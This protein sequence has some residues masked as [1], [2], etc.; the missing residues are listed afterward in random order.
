MDDARLVAVDQS[1]FLIGIAPPQKINDR[2][3]LG[4]EIGNGHVGDL[5][6]AIFGMTV[7][8]SLPNGE[9]GVEKQYPLLRPRRQIA[10]SL[11]YRVSILVRKLLV[12]VHKRRREHDAFPDRKSQ[13]V[14]LI[15]VEIG[16]LADDDDFHFLFR[17]QPKGA[18]DIL[19]R[20]IDRLF[21]SLLSSR[22]TL[23]NLLERTSKP[24]YFVPESSPF[25]SSCFF[26]FFKKVSRS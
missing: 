13:S 12:D 11:R 22:R 4:I 15:G 21:D 14:G 5:V 23:P 1:S 3:I 20:R 2:P 16:I 26:L 10:V 6:P 17:S 7:W 9:R 8:F 25:S 24:F 18:I 19:E